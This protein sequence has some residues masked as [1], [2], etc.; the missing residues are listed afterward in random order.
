MSLCGKVEKKNNIYK[1]YLCWVKKSK[2]AIFGTPKEIVARCSVSLEGNATVIM[3]PDFN[4]APPAAPSDSQ[5]TNYLKTG[6]L[7]FVSFI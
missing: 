1:K 2:I 6:Q 5:P 3:N 4:G 7:W